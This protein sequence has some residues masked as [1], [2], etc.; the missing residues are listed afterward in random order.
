[1]AG[2]VDVTN[3]G[4]AYEYEREHEQHHEEEEDNQNEVSTTKLVRYIYI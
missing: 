1:M 4:E 2:T 3:V